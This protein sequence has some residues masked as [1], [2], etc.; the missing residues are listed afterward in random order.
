MKVLYVTGW[1]RSGT[2]ILD[3]ILGAA[4]GFF[5]VGELSYLW[6]RGLLRGGRCGCGDLVCDCLIWNSVLEESFGDRPIREQDP[7][8][9]VEWQRSIARVRHTWRILKG[10]GNKDAAIA[11]YSALLA[12]VYKGVATVTRARVIV[13]SSKRPSGAALL[14]TMPEVEPYVLHMVRDPRA[15]AYSWQRRKVQPGFARPGLMLTHGALDSTASWTAWNLASAKVRRR[16]GPGRSMVLRYEDFVAHPKAVSEAIL[17]MLGEPADK[18]PFEGERRVRLERNHTV[19][20]NPSRFKSGTIELR[21]DDEWKSRQSL[22]DRILATTLS[23]PLLKRY[24]YRVRVP[25]SAGSE[26]QD[27]EA[28]A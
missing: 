14:A 2:T 16:L 17:R 27:Q 25:G 24:G 26:R 10:S 22:R 28:A 20:G 5:S 19:S 15:V 6:K 13:D 12:A 8:E 21:S 23:A 9:V 11:R 4:D 1:G 7:A 18:L 3:N